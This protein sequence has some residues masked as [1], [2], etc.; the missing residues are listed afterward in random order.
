MKNKDYSENDSLRR[1]DKVKVK[2]Y[3]RVEI[4]K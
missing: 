1:R 2:D 3:V 4:N